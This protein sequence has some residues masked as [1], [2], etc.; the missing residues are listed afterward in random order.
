MRIKAT[1]KKI[2]LTIFSLIFGLYCINN[3]YAFVRYEEKNPKNKTE[4]KMSGHIDYA[5]FS[6]NEKYEENGR[7]GNYTVFEPL[8]NVFETDK[9]ANVEIDRIVYV[10]DLDQILKKV[11]SG[12]IDFFM[13]AYNETEMFKG[14]HLLYPAVLYNPVTVF[15]LP[16]RINEV[17][18][19]EDLKKLKGIRN[20]KEVFS[21]FVEK[22]IKEYKLTAVDSPYEAF[23]KLFTRE[24]DYLIS[25]Y[26][27]GMVEAIKLGLKK[28]IAPAKQT[29]WNIPMFIGVS[30]TSR[31]REMI[32]KRIT[33]YLTDKNNIKSVEQKLQ[34]LI[35]EFEQRYSGVVPPTFVRENTTTEQHVMST[36]SS[37]AD[38]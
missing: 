24:A 21:D 37:E 15:M 16:N 25:S 35:T 28:Q 19:T 30:K 13:G 7:N 20:S 36:Q 22:R 27:N 14:L 6:W 5:P 23:E 12:E 9:E 3:V 4:L 29:L 34:S 38:N 17:S 1:M 33:K 10:K 11:R 8:I 32:S 18:S 31:N 2:L 26:Y